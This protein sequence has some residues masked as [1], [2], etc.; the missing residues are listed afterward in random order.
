M[1]PGHFAGITCGMRH[2]WSKVAVVSAVI[3]VIVLGIYLARGPIVKLALAKGIGMATGTSVAI[4]GLQLHAHRAILRDVT[5][6]A[7]NQRLAF[8]PR[9]D[10]TYDLHDLLHGGN[11]RYGLEALRMDNPAITVVRNPDGTY[12]LPSMPKSGPSNKKQAPVNVA[13]NVANGSLTLVDRTNGGGGTTVM[14]LRHVNIAGTFNT[15]ARTQYTASMAYVAGGA[16]YPIYGRGVLDAATGL[17]YQHYTARR[18]PLPQLVNFALANA[19][20]RLRAGELDGLNAI[21]YGKFSATANLSGGIVTM[22]G[23]ASPLQN[24]HGPLDVTSAALSTQHIDATIAGAPIR[25]SGAIFDLAHPQ[26]ALT[27]RASGEVARVKMLNAAMARLPMNGSANVAVLAEGPVKSPTA[28]ILLHSPQIV[29]RNLPLNNPNGLLAYDGNSISIVNFGMQYASFTIGARGL[30]RLAKRGQMLTALADASAPSSGV[31]YAASFAPGSQLDFSMLATAPALTRIETHGVVQAKGGS[32]PLTGVFHVTSAGVGSVLLQGRTLFAKVALD[33]P[34][35]AYGAYLNAKN[36]AIEPAAAVSLP[37]FNVHALPPVS[38]AVSG[39]AFASHS[40]HATEF[41]ANLDLRNARY[42]KIAIDN[43]RVDAAAAQSGNAFRGTALLSDAVVSKYPVRGATRFSY[44]AG[45]LS[46]A[47]AAI[48]A[49]PALALADG[50]VMP[51]YDLDATADGLISVSQFQ[52]DVAT[53]VHVTGSTASPVFT[54]FVDIPEGSVHGLALRD[55]HGAISG[56]PQAVTLQNGSVAI[57]STMLSF[58]ARV[59]PDSV[60]AGLRAPRADLADFNDYFDTGDTL[61]GT[62]RLQMT[63]AMTPYTLGSSG[64]VNLRNV[65]YRRFDLGSTVAGWDT[66]GTHTRLNANVDSAHGTLALRGTVLPER[67]SIDLNVAA[68]NL[69]LASW[70]PLLGINQPV[71]G[72]LDANAA[73]RGAYP[74]LAINAQAGVAKGTIGRVPLQRAYVAVDAAGGR[75]RITQ[76]IVQLPY[77]IANGSGTFGLHRGDPLALDVR[78]NSSDVGKLMTT[79]SGKPNQAGGVLDSTLHL[80][81]TA[82]DPRAQANLAIAQLRYAKFTVPRVAM[83]AS[84]DK[85]EVVIRNGSV[86]L[87]KG[88][89]ALQG[90]APLHLSHNAPIAMTLAIHKVDLSDFTAALPHG[91]RVTGL[92]DGTLNVGGTVSAPQLNG[93]VA[94]AN[95]YFVGP[96]DQNPISNMN[97]TLRFQGTAIALQNLR[98]KVGGG[99]FAMNMNAGVPSLRD[100]R[101]WTFDSRIVAQNAQVNSPQYFRGKFNADVTAY[102]RAGGLPT[103]NGTVDVPSGRI[104]LTAFWNPKAKKSSKPVTL[105]AAFNL[106]ANVGND[107]RVQS[108]Q[109]DVGATGSVKVMGTLEQPKLSGHIASTGGSVDFFRRF[110]VQSAHIRFDPADGFWPQINAIADTQVP[111]PL[112]YVQLHVTG[113]APNSLQLG[114]ISDPS[115]DQTQILGLL[116]GA[117]ALGALPGVAAS[118]PAG[119]FSASNVLQGYALGQIDTLFTQNLFEPLDAA[120]GNALGLQNLQLTDDFSSG[121]GV[122]AAKAFGK[123]VTAVFSENLGEPREQ[124]LSLE[125][126]HGNATAFDLMMYSVQAPPLAGF[127][128]QNASNP[129]QFNQLGG[130]TMLSALGGT[131]GFALMWEHKFH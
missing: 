62:G 113:L 38:G 84:V 55:L 26:L 46:V 45:G 15:G 79:F 119:G 131:N 102:R 28:L 114:L 95:G 73:V 91:S 20:I 112:T 100:L 17:N 3:G 50:R 59:A 35:N 108:P 67:K 27:V 110:T 98:A 51:A 25:L 115:Y 44:G 34:H 29:Y 57:G 66:N 129:F 106:T 19:P 90:H 36:L 87:K 63:V 105:N 8:V 21:Y 24:V 10:V 122:S 41:V 82:T 76:A 104:P 125:A 16:S 80:R 48:S 128:A 47:D 127:L 1:P 117:Q 14:S 96:V 103:I 121:F 43:A 18:I 61:A 101:A 4:G 7:R 111:N 130:Q 75:G 54:G 109:V 64:S 107:V 72:K 99:T 42:G 33:H 89:V 78:A 37:G 88:T 77:F 2:A 69:D 71:T 52:G 126:H 30:I 93:M 70:L 68:R 116:V 11:H 22:R 94:L 124:S 60:Q 81:G 74:D 65:R 9:I 120:L 97:G 92:L 85:R 5:L 53:R 56:T 83:N 39:T 6:S 123:H 32:Q 40:A 49:G 86:T 58:G 118:V 23:L 31:P 12:N 13:L